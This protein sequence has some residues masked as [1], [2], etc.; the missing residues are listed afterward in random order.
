M[1]MNCDILGQYEYE[2]TKIIILVPMQKKVLFKILREE[3]TKNV[4]KFAQVTFILTE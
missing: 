3:F 1:H 2:S 4:L